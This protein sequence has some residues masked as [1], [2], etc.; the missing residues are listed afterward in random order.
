MTWLVHFVF[1]WE[2][3]L[4]KPQ[5]LSNVRNSL[6][7]YIMNLRSPKLLITVSN[8]LR[9]LLFSTKYSF[10][11]F[12]KA[13]YCCSFSSLRRSISFHEKQLFQ[14]SIG[15]YTIPLFFLN[16][17]ICRNKQIDRRRYQV[18]LHLDHR[19]RDTASTGRS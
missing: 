19:D 9:S 10:F 17:C 18:S 12:W 2:R 5:I 3:A 6:F 4:L 15:R 14:S 8:A 1:S 13:W 11:H 16:Y 7:G